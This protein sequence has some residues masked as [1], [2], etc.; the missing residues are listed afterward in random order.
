[1]MTRAAL[2]QEKVEQRR[3]DADAFGCAE[4]G[5]LQSS[6]ALLHSRTNDCAVV[7]SHVTSAQRVEANF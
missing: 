5:G 4:L 2:I 7:T 1:M 6:P 3:F